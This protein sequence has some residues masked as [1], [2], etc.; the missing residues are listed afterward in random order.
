MFGKASLT[1]IYIKNNEEEQNMKYKDL[2][3]GTKL[4][5]GF[6]TLIFI[7][8]L[9]GSMSIYNMS[10]ISKKS[11][12]LANEYIP[13]V[14]IAT[15]LRGGANRTMFEMR[16]YGFSE[17]EEYYQYALKEI[18]AV[19]KAIE[20]GKKLN[21]K[22]EQLVK[23]EEELKIAEASVNQYTGL[24]EETQEVNITLKEMRAKMDEFAAMYMA[25]CVSYRDNQYEQMGKEIV[26]GGIQ[27]NRLT[28]I[29][30]INNIINVGNEIRIGNFKSQAKRDPKIIHDALK[31]F[32]EVYNLIDEIS[33]YTL[34]EKNKTAIKKIKAETTSYENAMISFITNWEKR[35]ELAIKRDNTGKELIQAC[36]G[37]SDAGFNGTQIAANETITILK[38]SN[39]IMLTGLFI[40]LLI[41]L[42][43]AV[44]LT[45]SITGPINKGV[46]FAKKMS[47]GDLTA[48]I[49]VEQKDEVGQLANALTNMGK[50]LLEIVENILS[51][52][53]SIT[54]ASQQL[55][56]TSQEMSQGASEQAS[57]VEE[58]TSSMEQMSANIEQNTE[59]AQG[60][61]K[62]ALNAAK[63]IKEGSTATNTAVEGMKNIAE[64]IRII[65][66]IAFQTNIL[67]LNA[68]V[69]AARAGEHGKGF[70]VVAAEVRKLAEHSKVAADE[71]D[72]LSR[73]GVN[74]AEKAGDKL[75]EIVPEIEK[76]AQ[77]VQE[78]ASASLEQRSGANQVNNAMEQLNNVTQQNAAASEE[79]ATSAEELA[80]QA[81]HLKEIIQFFNIGKEKRMSYAQLQSATT[82]E[83]V[84]SKNTH[85]GKVNKEAQIINV[86]ENN[87]LDKKFENF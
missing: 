29:T 36:I 10:M 59:N 79:M 5:I 78:I 3:L 46:N 18:E 43:F 66:D 34:L 17:E 44:F 30:L 51:G 37:M 33:K 84:K 63:G 21:K 70:A 58:V 50:K 72:E 25:N 38:V 77:L 31:K 75:N 61:E 28:K 22:A 56:S 4:A 48:T 74:I 53:N 27:R 15:D 23:L 14:K 13:E 80:S 87:L 45:R 85:V 12:I 73:N 2:K 62:I 42:A 54:S 26:T 20:E 16:G 40:A 39:S 57:S 82:D 68:A 47:E 9:L 1:E 81:E 52:A 11:R 69:E 6:G 83:K 8:I 7:S 19:K 49:E 60:T 41:G 65:N 71:I 64:K 86:Q 35:E 67:A 24:V 76:T 32:P 55:S